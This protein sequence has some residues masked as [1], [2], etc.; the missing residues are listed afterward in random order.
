MHILPSI[1]IREGQVVRLARGDYDRQ[2]TY[3]EDPAA[4]AR[5]FVEAGAEWIHV[6]D[7]DA[8]RTGELKNLAPIRA[9]CQSVKARIEMGGGARSEEAI[10][11]ILAAGV[12]RVVVGSQALKDWDWFE[13]FVERSAEPERIA[14]GL[15]ARQGKLAVH[16]W[17][18]QTE[19]D[20]LD[21]AGRTRNWP[22]GAIVYTDISRDG[23]LD[24]VNIPATR[25]VVEATSVP[26][27]AS[28]GVS[29]MDDL[30]DCKR[31][32]C[33]GAI[34][35]R[36]YYEGKIDLARAIEHFAQ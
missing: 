24:G 19:L 6:V 11:S 15:D 10:E 4:V 8:A 18:R 21:V 5:A 22:L 20:A 25:E 29:S 35:G 2:T 26:V 3:G 12:S 27:I 28:G 9:I 33:A 1:D 36:A 31:A 16:G 30:W 13:Q 34:V 32:G 17:T 7:L 14:L 23:M